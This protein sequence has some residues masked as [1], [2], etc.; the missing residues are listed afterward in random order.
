MCHM[1]KPILGPYLVGGMVMSLLALPVGYYG[2]LMLTRR[3]RRLH[4]HLPPAK[5]PGLHLTKP[6]TNNP[7][8]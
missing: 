4:L 5:L 6:P 1:L 2:M 7:K 3:L 8:R